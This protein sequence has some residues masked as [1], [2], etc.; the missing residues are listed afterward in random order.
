MF[1][2]A[3]QKHITITT[4]TA[5]KITTK[6]DTNDDDG[7]GDKNCIEPAQH[8]IYLTNISCNIPKIVRSNTKKSETSFLQIYFFIPLSNIIIKL[9]VRFDNF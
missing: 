8:F 7:D 9:N 2:S 6:G 1:W 5:I 3:D 4:T